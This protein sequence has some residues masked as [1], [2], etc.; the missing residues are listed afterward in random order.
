VI[1]LA[2][3]QQ[4]TGFAIL[5]LV[6]PPNMRGLITALY[7]LVLNVT[8]GAFGAVLVGVMADHW[9]GAPHIGYGIAVIGL[10]G[11]PLGGLCFAIVRPIYRAAVHQYA[12][13]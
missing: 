8:S 12:V 1:F 5:V 9:F 2:A 6:T 11:I 7:V 3:L 4:S 10:V 13:S